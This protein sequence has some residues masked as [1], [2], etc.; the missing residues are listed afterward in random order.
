M[1]QLNDVVSACVQFRH[2]YVL[3][4]DSGREQWVAQLSL[5]RQIIDGG[6]GFAIDS[7]SPNPLNQIA[8]VQ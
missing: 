3:V 5:T 2:G 6:E 7:L 8:I 4:Y 1:G